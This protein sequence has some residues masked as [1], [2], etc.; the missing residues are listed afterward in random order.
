ML[1]AY[2]GLGSNLGDRV[3]N[4]ARAVDALADM[5]AS[6]LKKVS[7]VYET[8]PL[9]AGQPDYVNAVAVVATELDA[10]QLLDLFKEIEQEGGRNMDAPSNAP[11]VIDVDLLLLGDTEWASEELEVPHPRM[12]ERDFVITPLL[13][14]DPEAS[15]PDGSPVTRDAVSAGTVI[16]DLGV[17]PDWGECSAEPAVADEWV[18]VAESDVAQDVLAGIDAELHFKKE[19]LEGECIP[20]AWDPY[21][22]GAAADP[23]GQ[24]TVFKL[25][26]PSEHEPRARA[27][28]KAAEKA[29]I[30]FPERFEE[31][32]EGD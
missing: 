1:D 19:V 28:L 17:V 31:P 16:S 23:W 24:Y 5:P 26:V 4:I 11:R 21:E 27:A 22:P 3:V 2:V 32:A 18:V 14:V 9:T 10:P 13:E 8:E 20:L 7:H 29:E 6:H 25:L 30:I 12:A 15:W